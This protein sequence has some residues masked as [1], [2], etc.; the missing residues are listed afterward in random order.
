MSEDFTPVNADALNDIWK[1]VL[2]DT[3]KKWAIFKF[4]TT[5]LCH[6]EDKDPQRHA[7]EV[8]KEW[9]PVVPGT[10][11][12]DF[13]VGLA[14]AVPGWIVVYA[15][16]DIGNYV[17]PDELEMDAPD[18]LS[19]GYLGRAKR[20]ADFETMKIVHIEHQ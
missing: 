19:I 2:P 16:E 10:P 15:N 18:T 3:V 11:L 8:M 7:L 1:K 12:G 20:H 17:S 13:N 6:E 9:G 5:V 14:G 4:G